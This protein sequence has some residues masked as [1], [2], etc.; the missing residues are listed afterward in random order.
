MIGAC[1]DIT[2]QV[3]QR[4]VIQRRERELEDI[5]E[6]HIRMIHTLSALEQSQA[7][8]TRML[9]VVSHDLRHPIGAAK[10]AISTLLKVEDYPDKEK[11]LLKIIERST[12][13]ALQLVNELLGMQG[14]S[15]E[16]KKEPVEL[17]A[18]LR[19]CADLL[20]HQADAKRQRIHIQAIPIT[21]AASREKL[22][23]VMSN[24]IANAIKF[25]PEATDILISLTTAG[26]TAMVKVADQGIG[27]TPD[28]LDKLF[29]MRT[30]AVRAGT[31]RETSYGM[32]LAISKQ[33]IDAHNGRIWVESLP[34]MGSVF[35]V[36]LPIQ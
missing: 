23:R 33:I 14:R 32:G 35:F 24:L 22:W 11:N 20:R 15:K 5:N 17:A 9:K 18:M 34:R 8:N 30:E 27:I 21:V 6:E 13:T 2:E 26:S 1:L 12:D 25:S 16:L 19:Y 4:E 36:E 31:A 3:N 29:S 28:M 7:D 10:M